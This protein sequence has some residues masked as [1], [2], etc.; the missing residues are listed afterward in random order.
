MSDY[1]P[2]S[3]GASSPAV[4]YH[5]FEAETSCLETLYLVTAAGAEASMKS[6]RVIKSE[7]LKRNEGLTKSEGIKKIKPAPHSIEIV[8]QLIEFIKTL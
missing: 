1:K 6:E 5:T 4:N 8:K 7:R 3:S 2:K